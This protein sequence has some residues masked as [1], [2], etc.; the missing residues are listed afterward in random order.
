[1]VTNEFSTYLPKVRC[2]IELRERLE[3]LTRR[4]VARNM[5]DHIR[6]AV[7][8]YVDRELETEESA[9]G[10]REEATA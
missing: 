8:Q 7:E 5:A 4:S 2:S 3:T 6:Y 1:M 10:E 9:N